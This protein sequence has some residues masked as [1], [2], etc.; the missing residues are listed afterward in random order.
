MYLIFSYVFNLSVS[1]I[2]SFSLLMQINFLCFLSVYRMSDYEDAIEVFDEV[3]NAGAVGP[4]GLRRRNKDLLWDFER[5]PDRNAD[6]ISLSSEIP[7]FH[8]VKVS[9]IVTLHNILFLFLSC[10]VLKREYE[11][12]V[13]MALT[14]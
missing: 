8:E 12:N 6:S 9:S 14:F 13:T 7:G 11:D 5:D 10:N 2:S 4:D 3:A 1:I